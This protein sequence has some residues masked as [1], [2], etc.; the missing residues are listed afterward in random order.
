LAAEQH[1]DRF[2]NASVTEKVQLLSRFAQL[3]AA[4]HLLM[5]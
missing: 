1:P 2:P 5:G 4:Y 3:S